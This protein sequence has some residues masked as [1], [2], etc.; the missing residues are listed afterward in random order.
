MPIMKPAI[1]TF[2]LAFLLAAC[3]TAEPVSTPDPVLDTPEVTSTLLPLPSDTPLPP[4]TA[5]LTLVGGSL[6]VQVNVRAGPGTWYD[7]L[8]LL[9]ASEPVQVM[10]QSGDGTW[11]EIVYPTA[12][13]GTGWVSAQFVDVGGGTVPSQ[14]AQVTPTAIGPVGTLSQRLNV[15]S[16]PGTTY[17][18]LAILET[19]TVVVL[20]GKNGTGSWFQII[21]PDGSAGRGWVTSAYVQAED[22]G[23]LPVLNASGTPVTPDGS[24]EA[25]FPAV[26]PTPTVG[27]A[28]ED[29][30][31]TIHP[32]VDV[33]F[34]AEAVRQFTFQSEV[35]TPD[36]DPEDWI[37]FTPYA[38]PGINEV[39]MRASLDCSGNGTL[40]V[41]L[42]KD[43]VHI[44]DW[45]SLAC[46]EHDR[47]FS[48]N[49]NGVYQL[50][51]SPAD[52]TGLQFVHY[53]LTLR[54]G[55]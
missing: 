22:T 20:T 21:Y 1:L 31:S 44:T 47:V 5:T 55:P 34:S 24:A 28:E 51:L 6:K 9:N 33:S 15:R 13:G 18:T 23:S 27:P 36:G 35:S 53:R 54:N 10:A 50:H 25:L 52:G 26:T 29:N 46:G 45:D 8:G 19:G 43:G 38:L 41:E 40:A 11:Y 39:L 17:D 7:S 42:W 2:I 12:S 49:V 48:L 4:A 37:G 3:G 32:V 14:T 30:D 16:G